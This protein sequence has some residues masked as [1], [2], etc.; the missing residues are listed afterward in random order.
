MVFHRLNFDW[1]SFN[2]TISLCPCV[3]QRMQ[4]RVA[5][6]FADFMEIL[7]KLALYLDGTLTILRFYLLFWD[8]H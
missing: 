1:S 2:D 7:L 3:L 5:F 6:A 8:S 4:K